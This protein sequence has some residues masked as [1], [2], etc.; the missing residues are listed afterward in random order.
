MWLR[1]VGTAVSETFSDEC[2][3]NRLHVSIDGSEFDL[4]LDKAGGGGGGGGGRGGGGIN[5]EY[6]S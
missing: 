3:G 5:P 1:V 6:A 4:L 2:F